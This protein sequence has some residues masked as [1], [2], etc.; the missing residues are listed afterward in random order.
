MRREKVVPKDSTENLSEL[1][2][3][4]FKKPI[5]TIIFNNE[6]KIPIYNSLKNPYIKNDTILGFC[7]IVN[8]SVIRHYLPLYTNNNEAKGLRCKFINIR[9]AF[10]LI[11]KFDNNG[12]ANK[13][14]NNL[15]KRYLLNILE[16]FSYYGK[17][18]IS[19]GIML[20]GYKIFKKKNYVNE[21][22][23][24][25]IPNYYGSGIDNPMI[26]VHFDPNTNK[27]QTI[28]ENGALIH[29]SINDYK[30][31]EKTCH[32]ACLLAR[33]YLI[34][35]NCKKFNNVIPI[36]II[37]ICKN[38][39]LNV[40]D[41]NKK[42]Y[43]ILEDLNKVFGNNNH[44]QVFFACFQD[45]KHYY[46]KNNYYGFNYFNL[47]HIEKLLELILIFNSKKSKIANLKNKLINI[48]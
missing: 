23:K 27:Y 43:I 2:I 36:C 4:K 11:F 1:D 12:F 41:I 44:N 28:S 38:S 17:V 14:T 18:K 15:K 9:D 7:Q 34:Q 33:K 39:K 46:I 35:N 5:T 25:K 6:I 42:Q 29:I 8:N 26:Y 45:S 19:N 32:S 21:N 10:T 24:Y 13:R 16:N 22:K 40:Y 48:L 31:K 20:N 47:I 30:T 3:K 37:N